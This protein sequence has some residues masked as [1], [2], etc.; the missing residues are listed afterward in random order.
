MPFMDLPI[1]RLDMAEAIISEHEEISIESSQTEMQTE[2]SVKRQ[3]RI[4]KYCGTIAKGV[5]K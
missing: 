1:N 2:K 4:F 3:N 5:R